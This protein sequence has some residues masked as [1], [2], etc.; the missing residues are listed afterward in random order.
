MANKSGI[1]KIDLNF[2]FKPLIKV[3]ERAGDDFFLDD[4]VKPTLFEGVAKGARKRILNSKLRKLKPNT[5]QIR[6]KAKQL[7]P[8]PL[9]RTGKLLNSIEATNGEDGFGLYAVDYAKLHLEGYTIKKGS[10]KFTK[11]WK[12]DVKVAP[13]NFLPTSEVFEL[14]AEDMKHIYNKINKIIKTHVRGR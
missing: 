3:L 4:K 1:T 10:N 6:A 13:R 5:V 7:P 9:F 2:D 14:S 11:H 12:K 8:A